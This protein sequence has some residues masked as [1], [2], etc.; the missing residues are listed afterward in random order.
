V[1]DTAGELLAVKQSTHRPGLAPALGLR[2]GTQA[3]RHSTADRRSLT[4]FHKQSA[5]GLHPR[6]VF[7]DAVEVLNPN[8]VIN[9]A[10]AAH[11]RFAHLASQSRRK[12]A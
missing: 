10:S 6:A 7:L 3:R 12:P 11:L 8:Y 5:A 1:K 9:S 4:C 2:A